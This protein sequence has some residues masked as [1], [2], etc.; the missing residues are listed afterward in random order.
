VKLRDLYRLTVGALFSCVLLPV[1]RGGDIAV[2]QNGRSDYVICLAEG[3]APPE[4]FAAAELRDYIERM[5]GC[6]LPVVEGEKPP[7]RAIL[8]GSACRHAGVDITKEGLEDPIHFKVTNEPGEG[9]I[10][11]TKGDTLIIA[12][13]IPRA[14]LYGVYEFLERLGCRF[15]TPNEEDE[16]VPR[17]PNV[18]VGALDFKERAEAATPVRQIHMQDVNRHELGRA[19]ATIDWLGKV[20]LNHIMIPI[21]PRQG[22]EYGAVRDEILP[23]LQKRGLV[24]SFNEHGTLPFYLAYDK[25]R[26]AGPENWGQVRA[27]KGV[28]RKPC[29]SDE[30][31]MEALIRNILRFLTDYPETGVL[32]LM[33]GDGDPWCHCAPCQVPTPGD[34]WLRGVNRIEEAVAKQCPNVIVE[35]LVGY[36][37]PEIKETVPNPKLR[38]LWQGWRHL[39]P[40]CR[41]GIEW[42]YTGYRTCIPLLGAARIERRTAKNNGVFIGM[43]ESYGTEGVEGAWWSSSFPFYFTMRRH[44]DKTVAESDLLDDYLRTYYPQSSE[45]MRTYIMGF[46]ADEESVP[47]KVFTESEAAAREAY[48]MVEAGKI[49]DPREARRIRK[50]YAL[51]RIVNVKRKF[52]SESKGLT[53]LT[54]KYDRPALASPPELAVARQ[55]TKNILPLHNEYQELLGGLRDEDGIYPLHQRGRS[56]AQTIQHYYN[57]KLVALVNSLVDEPTVWW[58]GEDARQTNLRRDFEFSPRS[59][60]E[61]EKLSN[62]AWIGADG[63]RKGQ[64]LFADYGVSVLRSGTHYLWVRK[65]YTHGAFRWRF[66]EA[67]WR[68]SPADRTFLED[69]VPVRRG[70]EANWV[71]LGIVDLSEGDHSFRIELLAKEGESATSGIDCFVLSGGAFTPRGTTRPQQWKKQE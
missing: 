11:R 44:W 20:R 50:A 67:P 22:C 69:S 51:V 10:I 49:K 14:T 71:Y 23:E 6:R 9:F 70:V 4:E 66:D 45:V 47:T 52:D 62:G 7:P 46:Q 16:V 1:V 58:E 27:L 59:D 31:D 43:Q 30:K 24:I 33:Y 18:V 42:G 68:T 61:R 40:H 63:V 39:Y 65:F 34:V 36:H 29:F 57:S 17:Q 3:P 25:F 8:I 32:G 60:A 54:Q 13:I 56:I 2:V 28:W 53:K 21:G 12:G 26:A 15:F 5:S 19:R 35:P 41:G 37:M 64:A 48:A 38:L 55:A